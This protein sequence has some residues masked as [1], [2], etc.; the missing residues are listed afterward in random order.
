[1]KK[2]SCEKIQSIL[3]DRKISGISDDDKNVINSHIENC[4][5]C[6]KL[7]SE[8]ALIEGLL[9]NKNDKNIIPRPETLIKLKSY[10]KSENIRP[11]NN[12][13]EK[14]FILWKNHYLAFAA[15]LI[16][17]LI[18]FSVTTIGPDLNKSTIDS[19]YQNIFIQSQPAIININDLNLHPG[20]KSIG[21]DSLILNYINA[22]M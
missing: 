8:L 6:R 20:G 18:I 12:K 1:M 14:E 3:I 16:F 15:V 9:K 17:F 19:T 10:L 22:S 2:E 4:E 5:A 11:V 21:E 13:K 7:A